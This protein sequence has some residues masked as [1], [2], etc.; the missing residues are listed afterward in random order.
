MV[1]KINKGLK[2]FDFKEN[3]KTQKI[4]TLVSISFFEKSKNV[5]ENIKSQKKLYS[6]EQK[7]KFALN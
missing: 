6:K 3:L 1:L 5:K 2:T 4:N 7:H